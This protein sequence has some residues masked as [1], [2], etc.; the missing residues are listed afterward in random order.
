MSTIGPNVC[1]RSWL[2]VAPP[3]T[4]WSETVQIAS[5]R[6]RADVTTHV[7]LIFSG[8]QFYNPRAELMK[9][10]VE[11]GVLA[12]ELEASA[13]YT[14]AA[15]YGARALAICTVSDHV[16]TGGATT[17]QEREQT[18]GPMVDIALAAAMRD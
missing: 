1:S 16:V 10:M 3:V 6:A 17:S 8:D 15:Q 4:T 2:V 18:F 7:G 13:L 12:V 11:H 14:L 5:A 9:P